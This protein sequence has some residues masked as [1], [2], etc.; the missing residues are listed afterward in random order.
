MTMHITIMEM[1][2]NSIESKMNRMATA[3]H[4]QGDE[5]VSVSGCSV[6]LL[7]GAYVLYE[8][9]MVFTIP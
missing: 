5:V 6:L 1:V 8:I 3:I 2:K 7:T 4:A 9:D